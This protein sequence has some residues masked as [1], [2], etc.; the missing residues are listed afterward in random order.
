MNRL[1]L[2]SVA[3]LLIAAGGGCSEYR[4]VAPPETQQ[5]GDDGAATDAQPATEQ[6]ATDEASARE[7]AARDSSGTE[8]ETP[9][10]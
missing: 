4:S 10:E 3:G 2:N 7:T 6:S 8:P 9:N 1:L 5:T